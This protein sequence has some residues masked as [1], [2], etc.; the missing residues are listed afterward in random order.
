MGALSR[1]VSLEGVGVNDLVIRGGA[2]LCFLSDGKDKCQGRRANFPSIVSAII[3]SLS[4]FPSVLPVPD[5][6]SLEN[7]GCI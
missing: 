7:Y 3:F 6:Q 2:V 5:F 4:V 1:V